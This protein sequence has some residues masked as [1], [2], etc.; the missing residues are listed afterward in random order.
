M[1]DKDIERLN[2]KT[3]DKDNI[4]FNSRIGS[5]TNLEAFR[6]KCKGIRCGL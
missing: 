5:K 4:K 6:E 1:I 2:D 3:S